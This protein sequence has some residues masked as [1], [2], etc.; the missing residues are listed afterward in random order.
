MHP[1]SRLSLGN[2]PV[3]PQAAVYR[4]QSGLRDTLASRRR[5]SGL[6]TMELSSLE[7]V[8]ESSQTAAARIEG[9]DDYFGTEAMREFSMQCLEGRQ[10]QPASYMYLRK[11]SSPNRKRPSPPARK[12]QYFSHNNIPKRRGIY[13]EEAILSRGKGKA[14]ITKHCASNGTLDKL[15]K[16]QPHAYILYRDFRDPARRL[17]RRVRG[18]QNQLCG[19]RL[20]KIWLTRDS[21]QQCQHQSHGAL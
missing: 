4:T 14:P 16:L 8:P 5:H 19:L 9:G 20:W 7:P 18:Q 2:M 3:S 15:S 12:Q 11:A 17:R 1:N 21:Q 6:P 10:R 13:S